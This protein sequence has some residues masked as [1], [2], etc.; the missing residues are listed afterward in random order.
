MIDSG[1]ATKKH[2]LQG[3]FMALFEWTPTLSVGVTEMDD[4]HKKLI[5]IINRLNEAMKTGKAKEVLAPI[6]KEM[7]D[8]TV[9][10]FGV[11]EGYMQKFGY[12]GLASQKTEH[13]KYVDRMNELNRDFS[14]GKLMITLDV[15][16]FLKEWLSKHIQGTDRQYTKLFNEKGLK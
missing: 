10:H 7:A 9:Y 13:K 2:T 4:Q 12:A 14:S 1:L 6:L 3:D 16:T 11:E 15:M 8:Y 5:D